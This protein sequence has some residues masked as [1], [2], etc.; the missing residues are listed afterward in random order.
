ME[1]KIENKTEGK[2]PEVTKIK[3]VSVS[4]EV[5]KRILQLI[6]DQVYQPGELMPTERDFAEMFGV[7][8]AS[9]REALRV[10]QSM[11]VV[12]KRVGSGTYLTHVPVRAARMFHIGYIIESFEWMELNEARLA[13]EEQTAGLAARRAGKEQIEAMR[14]ANQ[15]LRQLIAC[16]DRQKIVA[17]D[18][19]VHRLIAKGAQNVFLSNML[20]ALAETLLRYNREIFTWEMGDRAVEFHEGVIHAIELGDER[21]AKEAMEKHIRNADDQL[22]ENYAKEDLYGIK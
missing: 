15:E 16:G 9:V 1:N 19:Q 12:E 7:S 10:L 5:G 11:E 14:K 13:L 4:E 21:G 22:R 8:R 6:E 18:F 3:H 2:K 17:C 20:E